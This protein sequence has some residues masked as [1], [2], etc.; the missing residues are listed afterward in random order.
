MRARFECA[1]II[2]HEGRSAGL[3]KVARDGLD[4]QLIQIQL[5]PALQGRG[6]GERLIRE[7]IAEAGREGAGLSLH[8]L[9]A[10]PARRQYERL[11]FRIARRGA[12]GSDAAGLSGQ[13]GARLARGVP[14]SSASPMPRRF[15]R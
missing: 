12:R 6:V 14:Q 15:L 11:G 3:F 13:A 8:V 10:N 1:Q 7:L 5:A 2:E 9:H 4:W